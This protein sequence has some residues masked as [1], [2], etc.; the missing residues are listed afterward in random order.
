MRRSRDNERK[1]PEEPR[2]VRPRSNCLKNCLNRQPTQAK[3]RPGRTRA[4]SNTS[5]SWRG[6]KIGKNFAISKFWQRS[7]YT[8]IMVGIKTDF[9]DKYTSQDLRFSIKYF[10]IFHAG[11]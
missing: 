5:N 3:A 9:T 2:F 4:N 7:H 8:N 6:K 10:I 1:S 11:V